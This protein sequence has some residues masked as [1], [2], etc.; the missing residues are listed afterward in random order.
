LKSFSREAQSVRAGPSLD[1]TDGK[2]ERERPRRSSRRSRI[3]QKFAKTVSER[4]F[5]RAEVLHACNPIQDSRMKVAGPLPFQ[6]VTAAS[7]LAS[8]HLEEFLAPAL[9][10]L[11]PRDA[12]HENAIWNLQRHWSK[13]GC[14]YARRPARKRK[15]AVAPMPAST[16]DRTASSRENSSGTRRDCS[17]RYK[18]GS[19]PCAK[20]GAR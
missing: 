11:A 2:E 17:A 10:K 14:L 3:T 9:L 16:A 20:A 19:V 13:A 7:L 1:S 4:S 6:F 5:G 12:A 15:S 18:I 8:N